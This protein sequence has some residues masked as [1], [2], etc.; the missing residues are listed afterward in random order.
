MLR[1]LKK[2]KLTVIIDFVERFDAAPEKNSNSKC[3]HAR[4]TLGGFNLCHKGV[5]RPPAVNGELVNA[6]N[7][8]KISQI[9]MQ[10]WSQM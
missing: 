9:I 4:N 5:R 3:M 6:L 8:C 7:W 2:N 10:P 1:L